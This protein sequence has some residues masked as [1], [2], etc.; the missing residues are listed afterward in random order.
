MTKDG[1]LFITVQLLG[2]DVRNKDGYTHSYLHRFGDRGKSWTTRRVEPEE[3][4][5][6]T[7]GLTNLLER[8]EG[9]P[10]NEK[11]KSGERSLNLW[12]ND[13]RVACPLRAKADHLLLR[14]PE[15]LPER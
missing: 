1:T 9:N 5:P 8:Q 2:Q 6:R 15:W 11:P 10:K 13:G 12:N 14:C 3:F 4:R 7:V